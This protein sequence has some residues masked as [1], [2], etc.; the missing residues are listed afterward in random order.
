MPTVGIRRNKRGYKPLEQWGYIDEMCRVATLAACM[1]VLTERK[2]WFDIMRNHP[3]Q[4][5]Y[6]VERMK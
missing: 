3:N 6:L 5:K 4:K 1:P 2:V